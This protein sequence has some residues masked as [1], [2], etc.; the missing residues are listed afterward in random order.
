[1]HTPDL[2]SWRFVQRTWP[3]LL[4]WLACCGL[5]ARAQNL[6]YSTYA[7]LAD[8]VGF[9]DGAST[10]ARF[11]NP[12]GLAQDAAGNLY[13]ADTGNAVIRKIA[14]DGAV[15]TF[16]GSPGLAGS[17]DGTG[18]AARFSYPWGL[19]VDSAGNLY[20]ADSGNNT[21]RKITPAAVVTTFA[22]T[23]GVSGSADGT[24]PAAQ[25]SNP[26]SVAIDASGN[27]YVSD[28]GNTTVRKITPAG[29]V[30]TFAGA[31]GQFGIADGTGSA[32]RFN[33]PDGLAIDSGGNLY[34]A[35]SNNHTIRRVTPAG[36]VTTFVGVPQ[37]SGSNDS[38]TGPARF[39]TPIGL[40]FTPGGDLL[41]TDRGNNLIRRVRS[42]G[43]V[44]TIGG[45]AG[46]AGQ[47]DGSGTVALF[48]FPTGILVKS[49]SGDVF[50]TDTFN[51][52]V[53]R[54]VADVLA[55]NAS[56]GTAAEWLMNGTTMASQL[57]LSNFSPDSQIVGQADF[58]FDAK[59]DLIVQNNLTGMRS[60]WLMDGS[61]ITSTVD[62]GV[63]HLFWIIVAAADFNADGRTDLLWQNRQT[64]Q[65]VAWL[66]NGTTRTST[67]DLGTFDPTWQ[68]AGTADFDGDG[69]ADLLAQNSSTGARAIWILDT[70][71]NTTSTVDLGPQHQ[72]WQ[73]SGAA[74]FNGD[75]KP[76]IIWQ[77]VF[78]GLRTIW[79][80]NGTART[81][82]V[83]LGTQPRAW[84]ISAALDT[85]A[86]AHPDLLWQNRSLA[87]LDF[88]GDGYTDIILENRATGERKVWLMNG[89]QIES[90]VSLGTMSTD[91]QIAGLADFNGDRSPDIIWQNL[92]TGERTIW[93]MN[94]LTHASTVDLG[95]Q[96]PNWR[97]A[98]AADFNGDGQ[99]DLVWQNVSTGDRTVW[100]MNGSTFNSAMNLPAQSLSWDI[101]GAADFNGDGQ[102]EIIWQNRASGQATAWFMNGLSLGSAVDLGT[103][104]ADLHIVGAADFS[105]DGQLDFVVENVDTGERVLWLMNGFSVG[106]TIP[107]RTESTDWHIAN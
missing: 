100:F 71:F 103:H 65:R 82:I 22:G 27:L 8:N 11:G 94:E 105:G 76:D 69:H 46:Q 63:Q 74:D 25:F 72:G 57:L 52:T 101:V 64:G 35:D 2:S 13:V 40:A 78:S 53:R 45:A 60:I 55:L 96:D 58:D 14:P 36:A 83:S 21:I 87:P 66:M 17:S 26:S 29:V 33:Y 20:V 43:I 38:T 4:A 15:S 56:T 9:A 51:A 79:M 107:L 37:S 19:A 85:N 92:A 62:L 86:D 90:E 5:S 50:V 49:G 93:I 23:A 89:T 7:G 31:P 47:T 97:I 39:N 32:A 84:M 48:D 68:I 41:V 18:S 98:G 59:L 54:G 6:N 34:V 70:N 67:V 104:D 77:D 10:D 106:T 42:D 1:M 30:T 73:I 44:S 95:T 99:I 88:D 3:V 75:S 28:Y 81:G 61:T 24:G 80:M 12:T 91:W 16:A 102:A